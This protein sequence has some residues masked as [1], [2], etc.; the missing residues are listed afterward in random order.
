[1]PLRA[2]DQVSR[3]IGRSMQLVAASLIL[4]DLMR[5]LNGEGSSSNFFVT[6]V[7]F[8]VLIFGSYLAPKKEFIDPGPVDISEIDFKVIYKEHDGK[9]WRVIKLPDKD[10]REEAMRTM[11]HP[12]WK[13]GYRQTVVEKGT[14]EWKEYYRKKKLK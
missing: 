14:P 10:A 11:T 2:Q 7:A 13:G 5:W 9:L 8:L 4:I 12:A 1:M 6:A 3:F